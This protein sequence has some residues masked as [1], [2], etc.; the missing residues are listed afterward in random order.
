MKTKN[1]KATLLL[2]LGTF[3]W[4]LTFVTVKEGVAL[5]D[6][7]TFLGYRFVIAALVLGVIFF[8]KFKKFRFTEVK[9]GFLLAL[10]LTCGYITQTIGLQYT[11]ASKAGFITGLTV[12]FVPLFLSIIN[13]ELPKINHAIS[14]IMAV[15]GLFLLTYS[16][17]FSMNIGD[18]WVLSCTVTYAI[19]IIGVSRFTKLCDSI[20]LTFFQL[21]F[22]GI[23]CSIISLSTYGFVVP[24]GYPVWQS[25]LFTAI[26]ASSFVFA[27]QIHYQ[28]VLSEI[29]TV[30]IFS[31]EPLFAALAG[32]FYL[33]EEITSRIVVGG[34]LLFSAMLVAEIS[35]KQMLALVVKKNVAN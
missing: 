1:L 28:K 25:I 11:S 26:F 10:P 4:G 18:L 22:V 35:F 13:K 8:R 9:Y 23:I 12:V 5:V 32:Y 14:V 24:Q 17:A 19:F 21:L 2:L 6:V 16:S 7:Y 34:L 30:I 33:H 15:A 20:L 29:K 3:F 27:I 31:F